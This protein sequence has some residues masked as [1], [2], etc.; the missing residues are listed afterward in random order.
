MAEIRRRSTSN[1]AQVSGPTR[2]TRPRGVRLFVGKLGPA[3]L[4]STIDE[5]KGKSGSTHG[6]DVTAPEPWAKNRALSRGP[7]TS[8]SAS[9]RPIMALRVINHSEGL[10]PLGLPYTLSRGAASPA[11]FRLR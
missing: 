6:A 10:S 5:K 8:N 11:R 2:T 4:A 9:N 1:A 7:N 3:F